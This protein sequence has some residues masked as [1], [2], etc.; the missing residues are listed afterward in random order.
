MGVQ[1]SPCDLIDEEYFIG[2]FYLQVHAMESTVTSFTPGG[3]GAKVAWLHAA[4]VSANDYLAAL[5]QGRTNQRIF[6]P[7]P[8][9]G[10]YGTISSIAPLLLGWR[11]GSI[12]MTDSVWGSSPTDMKTQPFHSGVGIQPDVVV[13]QKMSDAINNVDTMLAAARAWLEE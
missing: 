3:L 11:G 8:T 2:D 5:I 12:Q 9:S 7:G 6:S 13:A 4:D 1:S 10:S